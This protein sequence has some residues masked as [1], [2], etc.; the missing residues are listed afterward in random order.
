M[1]IQ[2]IQQ[3]DLAYKTKLTILTIRVNGVKHI[4]FINCRH[5]ENGKAV[6]SPAEYNSICE[7]L[8]VKRGQTVIAG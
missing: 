1:N 6:L 4:F 7:I 2:E 5:N 3:K 8:K